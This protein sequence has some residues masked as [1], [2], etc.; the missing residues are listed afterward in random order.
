VHQGVEFSIRGTPASRLILDLNY[1]YLNR[2][3][4]YNFGDR[5]DVS[6]VLTT[7]QI[8]PTYPKNKVIANATLRLPYE[9][10]AFANYRYEGG[11]TLQDTTY[12]ALPGNLPF[13]N[14]YGT[15]DLGTVVP[16]HAGL[17]VQAG[18]K[19]LLDRDYYYTAGFP[20]A[21]RNWFLN[22]RYRF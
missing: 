10:L 14:S 2:T 5:V 3:M 17:S 4:V 18:V 7:V 19:N 12:R 21:G 16:I 13:S 8:L 6:K 1:S 15:V 11:I 20:E 9:V 22:L